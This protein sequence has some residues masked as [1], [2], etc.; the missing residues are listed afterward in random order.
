MRQPS[1]RRSFN[2]RK[3]TQ[4]NRACQ[5]GQ[6]LVEL[7]LT[8]PFVVLM[9]F[10]IIELGRAWMVYEGAKMAA[11]DGAYTAS[12]YHNV[13][14][15]E[16]QLKNKLDAAGL[17]TKTYKVSQVRDKHAY[18]ANVTVTFSPFF[19]GLSI[20]T[21]SGSISILPSEFDISY[22]AVTDVAIY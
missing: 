17:T 10:F 8:L 21:L 5:R 11:R 9:M 4:R 12:I 6:N 2:T 18:E 14:A 7:V 22:T 1:P 20:P 19:G 15:G 3:P 16:T 13:D